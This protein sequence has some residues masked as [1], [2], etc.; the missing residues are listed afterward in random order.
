MTELSAELANREAIES[1]HSKNLTWKSLL[2]LQEEL[3]AKN[4]LLDKYH[5]QE[6]SGEFSSSEFWEREVRE[7]NRK[8]ESGHNKILDMISELEERNV[9]LN[10]L[11]HSIPKEDSV[12]IGEIAEGVSGA[13]EL[14]EETVEDLPA[15]PYPSD[16]S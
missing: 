12:L 15:I 13:F 9:T 3:D 2:V 4:Q 11:S 10:T 16:E 6:E 8:Y 1:S 5:S 14:K 7:L